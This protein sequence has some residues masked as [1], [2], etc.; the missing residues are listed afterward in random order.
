MT[1]DA[2]NSDSPKPGAAPTGKPA[3]RDE[4]KAGPREPKM[5]T[6]FQPGVGRGGIIGYTAPKLPEGFE[7]KPGGGGVRPPSEGKD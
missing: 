1:K 3:Q 7:P 6:G 2:K 5:P 4:K